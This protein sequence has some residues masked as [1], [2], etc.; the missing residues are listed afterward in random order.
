MI[1]FLTSILWDQAAARALLLTGVAT[2]GAYFLTPNTRTFWER[3]TPAA[4]T[5]LGVG[6]SSMPSGRSKEVEAELAALRAEL[7]ALKSKP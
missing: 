2:A 3:V 1:P 7:D 4:A 6:A 5:A